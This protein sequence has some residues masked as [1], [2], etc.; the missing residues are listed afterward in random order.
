MNI[1]PTRPCLIKF[2]ILKN[3]NKKLIFTF[4]SAKYVSPIF[5]G[6][7]INKNSRITT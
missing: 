7:Y 6:R 1:L 4:Y 5:G 3:K 2:L